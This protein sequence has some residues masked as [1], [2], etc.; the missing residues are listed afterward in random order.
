[1]KFSY[2]HN[3]KTRSLIQLPQEGLLL[4]TQE[5][6]NSM[7]EDLQAL[8]KACTG[9]IVRRRRGEPSRTESLE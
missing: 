1:M 7:R 4:N 8:H 5:L 3:Y 2:V 9:N 6:S